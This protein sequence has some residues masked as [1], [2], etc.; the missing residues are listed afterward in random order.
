VSRNPFRIAF[1]NKVQFAA[2]AG[3]SATVAPD[4]IHTEPASKTKAGV[5]RALPSPGQ[6]RLAPERDQRGRPQVGTVVRSM[7]SRGEQPPEPLLSRLCRQLVSCR[8]HI[9]R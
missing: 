3:V 8:A 6:P 4:S 9:N 1:R 7:A 5:P 2:R